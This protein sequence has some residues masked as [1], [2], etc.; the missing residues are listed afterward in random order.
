[1]ICILR[2]NLKSVDLVNTTI[3]LVISGIY[4]SVLV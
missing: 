4:D 1:M 2:L 3:N